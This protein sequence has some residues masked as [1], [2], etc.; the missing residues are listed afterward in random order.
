MD[1]GSEAK[2][3]GLTG[4]IFHYDGPVC[5]RALNQKNADLKFKRFT[6]EQENLKK[7]ITQGSL[8]KVS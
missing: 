5:F 6:Q 8:S 3:K 1:F 2:R 7:E 4:F